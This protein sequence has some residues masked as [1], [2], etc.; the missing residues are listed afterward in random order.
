MTA[1]LR[2]RMGAPETRSRLE[3]LADHPWLI[4]DPSL[5][6]RKVGRRARW[7][8]ALAIAIS[9]AIGAVVV[10]GFVV[11]ALPKPGLDDA[12]R[13]LAINFAAAGVYL[14]LA[15]VIGVIWGRWRVESGPRGTSAWLDS[16]LEPDAR[17]RRRL[18]RAPLRIMVVEVVLWGAAAIG[19]A[20][21][22]LAFSKLLAL[23]V[24]LTVALG[25][26][27]TSAAAFLLSEIA[28][29]PIAARALAH[30]SDDRRRVSGVAARWLLAWGLGTGVPVLGLILVGIVGL[31]GVDIATDTLAL[32]MIV[33]GSIGL[34]F[35]ASLSVLAAYATVH[36]IRSI[37]RGL[38]RVRQG[39]L[40]AELGVWDATEVG[41]LQTGFNDMVQGLRERERIRDVFGRQV[42][43]DVAREALRAEIELGGETRVV[44]VLF[45]DLVG[46]TA[47]ADERPPEEVV[48][49]LNAFFAEVVDVV[50]ECGG[51]INK[52][53]GDAA[54]AVFGAPNPLEDAPERALRAARLLDGR[55]R[56]RVDAVRAGVGV[57]CGPA[58][59]GNIGAERRFEYTVIGD[60]VNEAARLTDLA[61]ERDGR[62]LASGHTVE[63]AGD[64]EAGRWELGD[65][66]TLRGR[67]KPTRLA[68][69]RG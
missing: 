61:K 68:E 45:V 62:V 58:V 22:N 27:T 28:L 15:L 23:G 46:S 66:V 55:L 24:G 19:F 35:G 20:A 11:L 41:Q 9:N 49:L 37:R 69:P 47:L 33:L 63:Q 31:T 4:G 57:A 67:S 53:M 13:V 17:Q 12:S 2:P 50:E 5:P 36:P 60:P 32:T 54:L 56:E 52:F 38:A 10:V 21:L 40:D 16:D 39:D 34:I 43:E 65:A 3:R 48:G 14:V 25:G 18:L 1:I 29:R 51:A 44:A 42:G 8:T 26:A 64:E 7:I 30:G 6:G 59:A